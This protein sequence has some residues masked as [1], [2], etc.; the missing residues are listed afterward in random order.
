MKKFLSILLVLLMVA[1]PLASCGNNP[2]DLGKDTGN[3][4]GTGTQGTGAEVADVLEIPEGTDFEGYE[5]VML[6][7][8]VVTYNY[9][10]MDFDEN[11]DDAY[12]NALYLRSTAVEELIGVTITEETAGWGQGVYDQFKL[13]VDSNSG[14]Y[15]VCFNNVSYGCTATGAGYCY[16]LDLF[17]YIDLEKSW[18]NKDCT[19]QLALGGQHYMAA[20]DIMLSDKECI[21]ALYFI[22]DLITENKLE[23]P[24]DLV[25]NN[26]WTW[27]KCHEMAFS[28]INDLNGSG[29]LD[30]SDVWGFLT[31]GEN[32]PAMWEA[33][34]LTLVS[35]DDDGIPVVQWNTEEFV[36][37]FEDIVEF[38]GDT[39]CVNWKANTTA[40][41]GDAIAFI[42]TALKEGRTLFGTEVIAF[43]RD[44]RGN[45][46]DFGILPLPKYSTDIERYN[47]YI[48]VNSGVMMIGKDCKDTV[49]TSII[50]ETL[51]AKG[52]EILIPTYY[53]GQ[54]SSKFSRDEESGEMLDIIFEN[55][56]YDLGV[57]FNWGSAYSGLCST[58]VN[59][60]TLYASV[61]KK[62]NKEIEKD[63]EKLG[64]S[65]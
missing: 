34:G 32:F 16:E 21:W 15:D 62:L 20:G 11:S 18:W 17:E 48:A 39:E 56:C 8:E 41:I 49:Q 22:K 6:T 52:A 30:S 51:A 50:L 3:A 37:V 19:N 58:D 59:P 61:Q 5:F 45:D 7:G 35:L 36:N 44:Y 57:F 40:G 24:Y 53:D 14:D 55:R 13:A 10:M 26:Q 28:A 63:F 23:N 43:V 29:A 12:E 38:M 46:Y 27:D 1:I 47:S 60:A 4:G 25:K 33:A 2:D 64:L 65:F 31:H 54:L 9:C 42:T